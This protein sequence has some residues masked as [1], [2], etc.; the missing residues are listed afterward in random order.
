VIGVILTGGREDG[1]GGLSEIKRRGG[2]AVVQDPGEALGATAGRHSGIPLPGGACLVAGC[3]EV[4][5]AGQF[6]HRFGSPYDPAVGVGGIPALAAVFDD[7]LSGVDT[8]HGPAV[9]KPVKQPGAQYSEG[10]GRLRAC[11][12]F[13]RASSAASGPLR[14]T[15][16]S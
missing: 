16:G 15:P 2:L 11:C 3:P 8:H 7:M 12:R 6:Q 10:I 4:G 1:V 13:L 14:D 5:E 9:R